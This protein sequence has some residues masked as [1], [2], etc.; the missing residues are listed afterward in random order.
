MRRLLV[1]NP[2]ETACRILRRAR[3]LETA[4][5]IDDHLAS[6]AA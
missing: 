3:G 1:A 6:A 2:G 4:R 5:L